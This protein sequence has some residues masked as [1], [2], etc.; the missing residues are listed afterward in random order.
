MGEK[1][2][3]A[4]LPKMQSGLVD[5]R[6][7]AGYW[8]AAGKSTPRLHRHCQSCNHAFTG[9]ISVN[10][11]A[12]S[13]RGVAAWWAAALLE[14]PHEFSSAHFR[15]CFSPMGKTVLIT[16]AGR[17]IGLALV[18]QYT[19][20]GDTVIACIRR[21]SDALA[22]LAPAQTIAADFAQ[23]DAVPAVVSALGSTRIDVLIN[24]AVSDARVWAGVASRNAVFLPCC[25]VSVRLSHCLCCTWDPRCT[26]RCSR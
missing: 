25:R 26:T 19:T 23:D 11:R 8:K 22:A 5:G 16:G 24:N 17:G 2:A 18:K 13:F 15:L 14:L 6:L 4:V 9:F 1:G 7:L 12:R 10:Q 3:V 21:P 20:A